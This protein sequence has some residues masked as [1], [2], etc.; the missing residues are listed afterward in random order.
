MHDAVMTLLWSLTKRLT[1][2]CLQDGA[3][4]HEILTISREVVFL[5]LVMQHASSQSFQL[6]C[7]K[8]GRIHGSVTL[9]LLFLDVCWVSRLRNLSGQHSRK[10]VMVLHRVCKVGKLE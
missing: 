5:W 4:R 1:V 6:C 2:T 7:G 8:S 9:P 3:R 10:S